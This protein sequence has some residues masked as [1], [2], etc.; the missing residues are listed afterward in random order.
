MRPVRVLFPL[1]ALIAA[2]TGS[3][4][5]VPAATI[6]VGADRKCSTI[7]SA[8]LIAQNGDTVLVSPGVYIEHNLVVDHR[9]LLAGAD[10]PV[11][12]ARDQGEII[13]VTANGAVVHGFTLRN[14][15]TSFTED[16]AGIRLR[17]VKHVVVEDNRLENAF[18]GIYVEHSDSVTI[19]RNILR[20][21][22]T[23]E[24]TTGNGIH[25]WYSKHATI[26]DNDIQGHRDG[27]YFEFVE[28]SQVARNVSTHNLRYG[29]HFMFSHHDSYTDNRFASNGAGVAVMYTH[30]VIMRGNV[31]DDNWGMNAYGLLLKDISDS[32]I[33]DNEFRNN[34]VALYMEGCNRISAHRNEFTDNGYAVRVMANSMQNTFTDNDFRANAFDVVTN[35][36]QSFNTF[37]SNYWSE[38][39][40]YDLDKDGVGDVPHRPVRLFALLVEKAPPGVVLLKSLFVTLIDTAERVMPV[41]TPETLIDTHPRMQ[42]EP[43]QATAMHTE[44]AQ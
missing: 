28:D 2:L 35:S 38:Y 1:L 15:G 4:R 21:P 34:T 41:F 12:D 13:T 20:G 32:D 36:R 7:A 31:F 6:H 5:A 17:A 33:R 16:C 44:A 9:I 18:F 26:E 30:D 40:G 42:P 19:R 27:I 29:L 39:R 23:R 22:H 24:T 10:H 37:D 8:L 14:V 25:L 3:V 43:F 11:I